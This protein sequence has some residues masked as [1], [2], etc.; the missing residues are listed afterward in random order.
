MLYVMKV[1]TAQNSDGCIV[2]DKFNAAGSSIL[3]SQKYAQKW[4]KLAHTN[5]NL[6]L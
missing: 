3:T 5:I 6:G 2:S 4:I 1:G